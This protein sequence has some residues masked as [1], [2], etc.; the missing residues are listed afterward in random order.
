ME[1][2]LVELEVDVAQVER[3]GDDRRGS[4][5]AADAF[6]VVRADLLGGQCTVGEE[7]RTERTEFAEVD[8]VTVAEFLYDDVLERIEYRQD[9]GSGHGTFAFNLRDDVVEAGGKHRSNLCVILGFLGLEILL[10]SSDE[11]NHENKVF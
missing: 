8:G 2:S 6:D 3:T 5:A 9:I 7:G 4:K 1:R 10:S 11:L